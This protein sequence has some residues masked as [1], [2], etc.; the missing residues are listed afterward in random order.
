MPAVPSHSLE[1]PPEAFQKRDSG[2]DAEFYAPARLVT[3]MYEAATEA[4][5]DLYRTSLP[6]EGI[7]LDLMSSWIS[8]LPPEMVFAEVIG[9]GM[10]AEELGANGQLTKSFVQDLN[11]T[12]ILPL[13]TGSCDVALCCLGVQY[14][15]KPLEVFAEVLRI[16]RPGAPFLVSFSNRCFP[17]K[18]AAI[19]RSLDSRGHASL[20]GLYLERAGFQNLRTQMLRD[21]SQSDPLIA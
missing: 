7:V 14:L 6:T 10:N 16:L 15:Q 8:H 5:T 4:L 12:Q 11:R 1:L 13:A 18:A 17:T 19:W 9:Q 2:D 3:H 21:G 20:V